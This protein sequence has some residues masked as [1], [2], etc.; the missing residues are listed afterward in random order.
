MIHRDIKG[1][2]VFIGNNHTV[3]LGLSFVAKVNLRSF[4]FSFFLGEFGLSRELS[5][6]SHRATTKLQGTLF[7]AYKINS[8]VFYLLLGGLW[9]RK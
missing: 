6:D 4:S 1:G 2:N 7:E 3:K 8:S 9:H 5:F